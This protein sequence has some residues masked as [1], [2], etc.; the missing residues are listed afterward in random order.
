[1]EETT[2]NVISDFGGLRI[3]LYPNRVEYAKKALWKVSSEAI[4][5]RNI[6]DVAVKM[7]G[8][9]P[10][11]RVYITSNDGKRHDLATPKPVEVREAILAAL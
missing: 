4:L 5:L 7:I 8:G 2:G 6:S 9:M 3:T 10:V 1:M 11:G